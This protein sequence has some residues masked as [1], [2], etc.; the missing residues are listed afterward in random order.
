MAGAIA[1]PIASI[2]L[3]TLYL[4]DLTLHGSTFQPRAVF[5]RLVDWINAGVLRPLVS[6]TYPL[7]AIAQA[8]ADFMAKTHP[9]KLVLIPP[10][11]PL[12]SH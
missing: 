7:R 3:R 9:G 10:P 2:D 8:Q 12:L 11:T 5:Q 1:G 6:K 4:K